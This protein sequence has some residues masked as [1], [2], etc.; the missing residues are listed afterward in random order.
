M[1]YLPVLELLYQ[2]L[3]QLSPRELTSNMGLDFAVRPPSPNLALAKRSL[4][5]QHDS[6]VS[7]VLPR[8]LRMS[9]RCPLLHPS[10]AGSV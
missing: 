8:S 10:P 9:S 1:L 6:S 4:V 5:T 2:N 7:P 3:K